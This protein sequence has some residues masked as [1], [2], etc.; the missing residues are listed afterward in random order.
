MI[1]S[2]EEVKNAKILKDPILENFNGPCYNLTIDKIYTLDK[3]CE[4]LDKIELEPRGQVLII[5]H[6]DFNLPENV[7]GYTTVKNSLSI[8]GIYALNIGIVDP[9]YKGPISTIL[10]NFGNKKKLIKRGTQVLRMTF[11]RFDTHPND[12]KFNFHSPKR[13]AYVVGRKNA[14][15]SALG[16]TFLS[17]DEIK[18]EVYSHVKEKLWKGIG[19]LSIV[20]VCLAIISICVTLTIFL[21]R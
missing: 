17:I 19:F 5:T 21:V 13:S 9:S 2:Q 8:Q 10:M 11:H 1:L 6:E 12:H 18:S 16:H 20:L 7:I 4:G 15:G 3:D 14:A